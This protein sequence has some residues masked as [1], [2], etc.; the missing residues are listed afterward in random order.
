MPQHLSCPG[1]PRFLLTWAAG[2]ETKAFI[3]LRPHKQKSG[4]PELASGLLGSPGL[5]VEAASHVALSTMYGSFPQLR[6]LPGTPPCQCE[7]K[8]LQKG[9]HLSG[10]R[11]DRV[12]HILAKLIWGCAANHKGGSLNPPQ[13]WS[14]GLPLSSLRIRASSLGR[15]WEPSLC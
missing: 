1:T 11:A 13:F 14:Q 3:S 4:A 10:T 9:L 7:L 5:I 6:L 2:P 8:T 12:S 15:V